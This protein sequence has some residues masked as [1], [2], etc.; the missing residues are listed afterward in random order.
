MFSEG[1]PIEL[2]DDE[3]SGWQFFAGDEAMNSNGYKIWINNGYTV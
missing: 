1:F 3:D 2:H